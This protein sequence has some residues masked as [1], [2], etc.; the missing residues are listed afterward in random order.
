MSPNFDLTDP[1]TFQEILSY[2]HLNELT[3]TKSDD[4]K[5]YST[6]RDGIID[7]RSSSNGVNS[8]GSGIF[9]K[10]FQSMLV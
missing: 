6:C 4:R 2:S 8:R 1:K 3:L 10:K 5:W 7:C 9:L